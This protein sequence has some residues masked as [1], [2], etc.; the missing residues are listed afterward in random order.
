[1][2]KADKGIPSAATKL[3]MSTPLPLKPP[4]TS[5]PPPLPGG[6]R[7]IDGSVLPLDQPVFL[8]DAKDTG[9]ESVE[10]SIALPALEPSMSSALGGP[11]RTARQIAP[12]AAGDED[13]E[14]TVDD[15]ASGGLGI[16]S[17]SLFR[18][19]KQVGKKLPLKVAEPIESSSH[20]RTSLQLR[21]YSTS[22]T[23]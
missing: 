6:K 7:A 5:S 21:G 20:H 9:L 14:Q 11:L 10:G 16:A 19:R 22:S 13:V 12:S 8:G 1:M 15:L 3:W 18:L 17:S 23:T 2:V 4:A